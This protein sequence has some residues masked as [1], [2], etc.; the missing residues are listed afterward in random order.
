M[1][2]SPAGSRAHRIPKTYK[3]CVACNDTLRV[4]VKY[5]YNLF[6]KLEDESGDALVVSVDE[7][8][9]TSSCP[10]ACAC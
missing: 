8:V 6:F 7:N 5:H 2:I 10:L 4:H 9:R 1:P 3:A